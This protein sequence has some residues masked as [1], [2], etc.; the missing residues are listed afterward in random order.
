MKEFLIFA[1]NLVFIGSLWGQV[2]QNVQEITTDINE[3]L[4]FGTSNSKT[5]DQLNFPNQCFNEIDFLNRCEGLSSSLLP[6]KYKESG[7]KTLFEIKYRPIEERRRRSIGRIV[8]GDIDKLN[9]DKFYADGHPERNL[10]TKDQLEAEIEEASEWFAK[11]Y[12]DQKIDLE[13]LR[14][15]IIIDQLVNPNFTKTDAEMMNKIKNYS[16][17]MNDQEFLRF[18]SAMAGYVDYNDERSYFEQTEDAGLGVVTPL[19][20]I[21][22]T[23]SGICGDIH[24][25]VAKIAEQRGWESF[26]VGYAMPES[27][28][29]ITAMVNPNDPNKLMIVNY[30]KY[31]E[32]AM[33]DTNSI[34]LTPT[35]TGWEDIGMQLRI[36]KNDKT[37]DPS[38]KM[39][40]IGTIP[41]ALGSFMSELFKKDYQIAKAMPNNQNYRIEKAGGETTQQKTNSSKDG[42]WISDKLVSDGFVIYE[43]ETDNSKIYGIAVNHNTYKDMYK[44]D[45]A[46]NKCVLKKNK[47]FS[48][49]LSGS[50]INLSHANL[51]DTLYVYL[52]I[53]GGEILH[54]YQSESFQF[55]GLI[56]YEF[57]GFYANYSQGFLTG[58][59]NFASM[60]GLASE[61]K[62][63][64]TLIQLGMTYE[65]NIALRNQNLMTDLSTIPTNINP[66]AFNAVSLNA[67]MNQK[68]NAN[69]TLQSKNSVTMT[70]LGGRVL[71]ST[72]V[73][74]RNTSILL[75]YEGGLRAIPIGNTI[76]SVN[77]LKNFNNIDGFKINVNQNF[78]NKSGTL[79]GSLSGY[80]GI[81]TGTPRPIPMGGATLKI[82]LGGKK[83]N[84]KT[85]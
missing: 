28:H 16:S 31:E 80:G 71:L 51:E 57:D 13:T 63:N 26:T 82:N 22:K 25:M 77:L 70:R 65:T 21:T 38:G 18:A 85:R 58:D 11:N 14:N 40:Q 23:K 66:I 78:R 37:G 42:K 33:N 36:F 27:H 56:G 44:W 62:K 67:D 15:R 55:K 54:L 29:V 48:A 32:D 60:L 59:A 76:Q 84:L 4:N 74:Y 43:G 68:L 17:S 39:Q 61:Y 83:N 47:Y 41:T 53:K 30:G 19:Q 7:W 72:G 64:G 24:S 45:S 52:N 3:I 8:Y 5:L 49:G 81:S 2:D 79:S 35:G 20:Q 6:P 75:S 73:L 9:L 46:Q 50:L 69:S 12:P 34:N 10:S 1:I